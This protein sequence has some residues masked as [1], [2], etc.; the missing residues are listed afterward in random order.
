MAATNR[1][2]TGS[3]LN[4][5]L[6]P[7]FMSNL[8]GYYVEANSTASQLSGFDSPEKMVGRHYSD[9]PD[10]LKNYADDFMQHDQQVWKSKQQISFFEM[11]LYAD[12][13][14]HCHI[15]TKNLIYDNEDPFIHAS[16][17]DITQLCN[18]L[19][20]EILCWHALP[21]K[22]DNNKSFYYQF[23]QAFENDS[24]LTVREM[25]CIRYLMLNYS[26]KMIANCMSI[27][28]KTVDCHI[29][30]IKEKLGLNSKAAI[31]SHCIT[32][33]LLPINLLF[34]NYRSY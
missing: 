16:L 23:D 4:A 27:S 28:K 10:G 21:Q 32:K 30:N 3:L 14:Y 1:V 12:G 25:E 31:I 13:N 6:H 22:I 15:G 20:C 19:I 2:S 5:G 26:N 29:H 33:R 34:A 18:P 17:F 8:D 7:I 9:L 11:F 24:P